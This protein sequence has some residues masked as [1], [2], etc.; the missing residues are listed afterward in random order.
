MA[1]PK[2]LLTHFSVTDDE[3]EIYL[4]LLRLGIAT[5][6]EVSDKTRK[7][8]TAIHFHLKK[9]VDKNLVRMTKRGRTFIFSAVAPSELATRFDRATTDF[10]SMVPQLEALQKIEGEAPRVQVTE[11]RAG[12][13]KIYDEISSLPEGDTFHAIE[14]VDALRNELTLL[15]NE[16]MKNFYSRIISRDIETKLIITEEATHIPSKMV[17]SENYEL[18][19][20][21]RLHVRTYPESALAFQGLSL[22]YG[23]TIAHLFP[24]TNL[25][26]TIKHQGIADSFKAMFD[27]LFN[28]GLS[29]KVCLA[30]N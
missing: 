12:Y 8:R 7:N 21:R 15:T 11:S 19:K 5:A 9:L 24:Q 30:I 1:N 20:K 25:V 4:A 23:D 13:F 29:R 10:K 22:M 28:A 14:G 6:T 18:L 17:T 27:T 2:E 26:V 16:E 3:A